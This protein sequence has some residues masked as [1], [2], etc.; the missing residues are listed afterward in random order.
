MCYDIVNFT[1][2]CGYGFGGVCSVAAG[3]VNASTCVPCFSGTYSTS[4]GAYEVVWHT[5]WTRMQGREWGVGSGKALFFRCSARDYYSL[6][7]EWARQE[8]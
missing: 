1:R 3:A 6:R 4:R 5:V 2:D 8:A 7:V